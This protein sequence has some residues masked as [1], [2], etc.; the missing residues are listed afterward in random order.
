MPLLK[1]IVIAL[2]S[3]G[4]WL[5]NATSVQAVPSSSLLVAGVSVAAGD[6]DGVLP[7]LLDAEALLL[8]TGDTAVLLALGTAV[9]LPFGAADGDGVVGAA[10]AFNSAAKIIKTYRVCLGMML[11]MINKV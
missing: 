6:S 3:S 4:G 9:L 8:G 7:A 5:F 11:Q 2:P 1:T 10:Q